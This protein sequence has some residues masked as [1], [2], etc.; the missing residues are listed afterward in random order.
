MKT[1]FVLPCMFLLLSAASAKDMHLPYRMV[2]EPGNQRIQLRYHNDTN[3]AV[4]FETEAWPNQAGK[5]NYAADQV[6][7]VV[8]N[9]RFPVENFNTG[10]CPGCMLR[11]APGREIVGY[12]PYTDFK[13]PTPLWNEPKELE[14][15]LVAFTCR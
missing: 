7:L 13:L 6:F 2:D 12:I 8:K 9:Q 10:I 4:C 5:L 3:S 1:A 11:V 14:Y 15:D